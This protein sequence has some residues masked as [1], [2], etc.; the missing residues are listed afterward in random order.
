MAKK[1]E[2]EFLHDISSPISVL[3]GGLEMLKGKIQNGKISDLSEIE[4]RLDQLIGVS[5]KLVKILVERKEF[6][7]DSK[8]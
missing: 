4:S 6:I 2:R 3:Q 1:N 5:E 7:K 8:D